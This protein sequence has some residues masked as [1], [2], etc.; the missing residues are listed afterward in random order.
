MLCREFLTFRWHETTHG[1]RVSSDHV[2]KNQQE[3]SDKPR[4]YKNAAT[5]FLRKTSRN[6]TN[7]S[8]M[9]LGSSGPQ[10]KPAPGSKAFW[11][12]K[13]F[14]TSGQKKNVP[15][16]HWL[17]LNWQVTK[18]KKGLKAEAELRVRHLLDPQ[19]QAPHCQAKSA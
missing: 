16:T 19:G 7:Q 2:L 6:Q 12:H 15:Q 4:S 14:L 9:G 11:P 18:P 8:L 10:T 1:H 13:S 3:T 5:M 17:P